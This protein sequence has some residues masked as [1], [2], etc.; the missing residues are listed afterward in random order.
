MV[1][2]IVPDMLTG[3][4]GSDMLPAMVPWNVVDAPVGPAGFFPQEVI[5]IATVI[6]DAMTQAKPRAKPSLAKRVDIDKRLHGDVTD[7]LDE[8]ATGK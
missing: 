6:K 5:N 4:L 8:P 3:P 1:T 7:R 2:V